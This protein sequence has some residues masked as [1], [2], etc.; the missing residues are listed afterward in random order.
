MIRSDSPP[1]TSLE[2]ARDEYATDEEVRAVW[3][4]MGCDGPLYALWC[5]HT[6]GGIAASEHCRILVV[7]NL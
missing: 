6:F 3:A 5:R 4:N 1:S 7:T 2:A